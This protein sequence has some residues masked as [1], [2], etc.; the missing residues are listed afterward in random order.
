[1]TL[2]LEINRLPGC[3]TRCVCRQTVLLCVAVASGSP[4][5]SWLPSPV[6]RVLRYRRTRGAVWGTDTGLSHGPCRSYY[7][8][9]S[10]ARTR[11]E[12]GQPRNS[13]THRIHPPRRD[14]FHKD[15][16]PDMSKERTAYQNCRTS[17]PNGRG[18]GT[19]KRIAKSSSIRPMNHRLLD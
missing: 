6:V 17:A 11:G 10:K 13:C 3:L 15:A 16:H 14:R 12:Y 8:P 18:G 2:I 9:C 7:T 19:R 4:Q 5:A 1:M